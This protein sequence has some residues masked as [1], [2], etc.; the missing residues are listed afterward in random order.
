MQERNLY[1]TKTGCH[2]NAAAG[3]G[4]VKYYKKGFETDDFTVN[5]F[6][7]RISDGSFGFSVFLVDAELTEAQ[8]AVF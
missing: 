1:K 3:F 6:L 5:R 8:V 2:S 7:D 4:R